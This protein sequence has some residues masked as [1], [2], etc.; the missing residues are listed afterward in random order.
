MLALFAGV[1]LLVLAIGSV[2]VIGYRFATGSLYVDQYTK[3]TRS[4]NAAAHPKV[5]LRAGLA[6]VDVTTGAADKIT[7]R[8]EQRTRGIVLSGQ[9]SNLSLSYQQQGDTLTVN[10]SA[11]DLSTIG[12]RSERIAVTVPAASA[13]DVVTGSGDAS[14]AGVGGGGPISVRTGSGSAVAQ[15]VQGVITLG[16]GS[17]DIRLEGAKLDSGSQVETGSGAIQVG[18]ADGPLSLRTGSGDISL[19]R[20]ALRGRSTATAGSGSISFGGTLDGAGAYRFQTASGNVRIGLPPA[21]SFELTA[22]SQS[23]GV[24]NAFGATQVGSSPRPALDVSTGSGSI[25][26]SNQG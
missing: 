4:F 12:E 2:G 22:S 8:S 25:Q 21:A 5:V 19:Q 16:T 14:V 20:T 11:A 6:R 24:H 13:V 10:A 3:S 7:V 26:I 18:S 17:G 1:L 15:D 23:G 9:P